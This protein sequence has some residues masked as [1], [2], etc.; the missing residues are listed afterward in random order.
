[1]PFPLP[2]PPPDNEGTPAETDGPTPLVLEDFLLYRLNRA[3]EA[4]SRGFAAIYKDRYG[5]TRPEWRCLATLGQFG[6]MTATMI[7]SHS[8]MH[9]TRVSRAVSALEKRRWLRRTT[10]VQDRRLE[11]IALTPAGRTAYADLARTARD[12]QNR[13]EEI[14]GNQDTAALDRGLKALET[15]FSLSAPKDGP[16]SGT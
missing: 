2:T 3:A 7:G 11:H 9:K 16:E 1:M 5:L 12:Y 15:A 13:L 14:L 8:S 6:Q 10:D 4:A